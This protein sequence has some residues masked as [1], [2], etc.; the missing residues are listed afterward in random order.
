MSESINNKI[1]SSTTVINSADVVID[2]KASLNFP[3]LSQV[4]K[5]KEQIEQQQDSHL[6]INPAAHAELLKTVNYLSSLT[7]NKVALYF[8]PENT[9]AAIHKQAIELCLKNNTNGWQQAESAIKQAEV[10]LLNLKSQFEQIKQAVT[11]IEGLLK[12]P[13]MNMVAHH[14]KISQNLAEI[15]AL[16][17]IL[18]PTLTKLHFTVL[19]AEA[20]DPTLI[21]Q[22]FD[23]KQQSPEYIALHKSGYVDT[24]KLFIKAS[25]IV[26]SGTPQLSKL[27]EILNQKAAAFHKMKAEF[28]AL[29][30]TLPEYPN[31]EQL[32]KATDLCDKLQLAIL[33]H[34]QLKAE[35]KSLETQKT[36]AEKYLKYYQNW[37]EQAQE[38]IDAAK[39]IETKK[40]ENIEL[41]KQM[42]SGISLNTQMQPHLQKLVHTED[43]IKEQQKVVLDNQILLKAH[44]ET[45]EYLQSEAVQKLLASTSA[46][47]TEVIT[48]DMAP[49]VV[50]IIP[51]AVTHTE[52][53]GN[54]GD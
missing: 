21:K 13:A 32:N 38:E 33:E 31:A 2:D 11:T 39:L 1:P 42:E 36:Q 35:V 8:S 52:T 25:D 28:E 16:E 30:T 49:V 29:K 19:A 18:Q 9:K 37:S 45:T 22:V 5:I 23:V 12:S 53:L 4:Q 34:D 26:Q 43:Q 40:Q 10:K 3:I 54:W 20:I 46:F 47:E 27:N 7:I 6:N 44:Q 24:V 15:K 51:P 17:L 50:P 14:Q 48:T 41:G